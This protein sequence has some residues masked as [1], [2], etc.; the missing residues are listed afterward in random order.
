MN[1]RFVALAL[2]PALLAGAGPA[3]DNGEAGLPGLVPA[4]AGVYF[5]LRGTGRLVGDFRGSRLEKRLLESPLWKRFQAAPEHDQLQF[6]LLWFEGHFGQRA[7]RTL[8]D[9]A[10]EGLALAL[11]PVPGRAQPGALLLARGASAAR[12]ARL[13]EGFRK[14]G[15]AEWKT[16]EVEG[17]PVHARG[18]ALHVAL[19]GR[20]IALSSHA[21]LLA[22]AVRLHARGGGGLSATE[23]FRSA[24]AGARRR[25]SAGFAF[26]DL[27]GLGARVPELLPNP[28]LA[29]LFAEH[30]RALRAAPWV[31]AELELTGAG[32]V[33]QSSWGAPA[34]PAR[35]RDAIAI[36]VVPRRVGAAAVRRDLQAFWEARERLVPPTA[37]AGLAQFDTTLSIFFSGRPLGDEL[38]SELEPDLLLVAARE[39][40]PAPG[41]GPRLP[42]FALVF[43]LREPD[44]FGPRLEVAFQTLLGIINADRGQKGLEPFRLETTAVDGLEVLTMR[45]L[46]PDP[47]PTLEGSLRWSAVRARD[48]FVL[49]S[50]L[51]LAASLGTAFRN[52]AL[53]TPGPEDR[54][55]LD[56]PELRRALVENE[57]Q[58]VVDEML[59]KGSTRA[60]AERSIRDFLDLLDLFAGA[61]VAVTPGSLRLEVRLR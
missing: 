30:A 46:A 21:G 8:A 57:E 55:V 2:L 16:T 39:E 40:Q 28:L 25:G 29:L 56:G 20:T 59:K 14:V 5:E 43:R 36:P 38:L 60:V 41:P 54:L 1:P 44:R 48:R 7:E 42:G 37:L 4:N 27:A 45:P 35:A 22:E 9:A 10:S 19:L 17:L 3:S 18:P 61:D 47:H 49:A 34:A 50:T 31:R 11:R 12:Q 24:A 13:I 58:L 51:G 26:L 53:E 23:G 33:L 52:G 15:E 32:A 6:A